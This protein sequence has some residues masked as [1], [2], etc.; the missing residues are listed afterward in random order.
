[1]ELLKINKDKRALKLAKKRVRCTGGVR[2]G[3]A[4]AGPGAYSRPD[5]LFAGSQL[6]THARGKKKRDEMTAAL[7]Q[8]RKAAAHH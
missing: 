1:M 6:G 3:R 7:T 4:D 5:P 8:M 2:S